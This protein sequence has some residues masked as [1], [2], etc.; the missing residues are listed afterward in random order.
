MS[1]EKIEILCKY[2]NAL[3]LKDKREHTRQKKIRGED[4]NFFCTLSCATTHNN[5]MISNR[6]PPLPQWGNTFNKKGDFSYYLNKAKGRRHVFDIDEEYLNMIWNNQ[7]GKCAYTG[8]SMMIKKYNNKPDFKTAS[9]DRIDSSEGY[10]KGNV[11]FIC[12]PFNLAK[13]NK[14][15]DEFKAFLKEAVSNMD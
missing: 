7:E 9:L 10:I 4:A 11:Q 12:V 15:D 5:S 13:G 3:F 14:N 1:R 2:C 6:T 8:L